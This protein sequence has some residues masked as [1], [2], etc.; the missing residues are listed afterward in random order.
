MGTS[1]VTVEPVEAKAQLR[2][3]RD[4]PYLLHRGDPRWKPGVRAYESWR[5]DSQRHP[6]FDRGDAAY[7]LARRAGQPAGRIVAHRDEQ[8]AT[9]AWFGFF[10]APDDAEVVEALLDAAQEWLRG[11]GASSMTGPVS[12]WAHE[13]FGVMVDGHDQPSITGRS[14]HPEWYAASLL[15][16]G[17][18]PGETR[19][20]FR[21]STAGAQGAEPTIDGTT[22]IPPHAGGYAD[23][24][25]V[26]ADI[27]AVP[28]VSSTL[29]SA[30]VRSAWRV[31]REVRRNGFDTAV[32]VR[33]DGDPAE[34]VPR[35]LVAARR[36][37][38]AWL[39]APWGPQGSVPE[40][41]HQVFSRRW[42]S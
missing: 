37:G 29:A 33:C 21:L 19:R 24:A 16:A 4:V 22:E 23:P 6:Y 35:L 36:A 13:E 18:E 14:W 12:W 25:L 41:V 2:R 8:G 1:I 39:I 17:M 30:S 38:Y 10:A 11:E 26:M 9:D 31:A 42:S 20:T 34:L 5:L 15:D 28:E 32:C 7:F 40:T 3:F 27:A